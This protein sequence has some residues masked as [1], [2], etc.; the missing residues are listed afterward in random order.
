MDEQKPQQS[1]PRLPPAPDAELSD[2]DLEDVAGGLARVWLGEAV[3]A[4]LRAGS[5]LAPGAP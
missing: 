1:E 3:G 5:A 2:A 4:G